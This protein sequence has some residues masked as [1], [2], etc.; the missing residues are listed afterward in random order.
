MQKLE[1]TCSSYT[2]IHNPIRDKAVLSS[3]FLPSSSI[4]SSCEHVVGTCRKRCAARQDADAGCR[5]EQSN[6][7]SDSFFDA[8]RWV[9]RARLRENLVRESCNY[10]RFLEPVGD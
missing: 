4:W 3:E 9:S 5:I 10:I 8:Y 2:F 7:P 1:T 6:S